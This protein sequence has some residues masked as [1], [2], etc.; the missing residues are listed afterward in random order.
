MQRRSY[1]LFLLVFFFTALVFPIM[2]EAASLADVDLYREGDSVLLSAHLTGAFTKDIS[3][4]IQSGA[5][6][7]F[8]YSV[9]VRQHRRYWLDRDTIT[10]VVRKTV[11]YDSFTKDYHILE[12]IGENE[13]DFKEDDSSYLGKVVSSM[14]SVEDGAGSREDS[15]TKEDRED[16][17]LHDLKDLEKWMSLL[18]SVYLGRK[19]EFSDNREYYVEIKATMKSIHLPMPFNYL[20]FF[21]SYWDFDTSMKSSSRFQGPPPAKTPQSKL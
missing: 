17:V 12:K 21:V 4:A 13:S 14:T 16:T 20:L 11:K 6:V 5:P 10:K 15:E 3:D 8:T 7:S 18:D 2:I 1:T 9:S 19:N